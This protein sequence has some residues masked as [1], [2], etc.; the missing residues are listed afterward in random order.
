VNLIPMVSMHPWV[1]GNI[2]LGGLIGIGIDIGTGAAAPVKEE[3]IKMILYE[4]KP[5]DISFRPRWQ[6]NDLKWVK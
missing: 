4:N 1:L 5:C 6:G 3:D 2:I